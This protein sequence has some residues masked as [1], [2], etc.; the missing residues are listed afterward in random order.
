MQCSL[1]NRSNPISQL[2]VASTGESVKTLTRLKNSKPF[3]FHPPIIPL[4]SL[5]TFLTNL[6]QFRWIST[7]DTKSFITHTVVHNNTDLNYISHQRYFTN[8]DLILSQKTNKQ[9]TLFSHVGDSCFSVFVF[10]F[11]N[12]K[13]REYLTMSR[14]PGNH[15]RRLGDNGGL[16]SSSKSRSSP[17]ISLGLIVVVIQILV[18][19]LFVVLEICF[20]GKELHGIGFL[21][22]KIFLFLQGALLFIAYSYRNSGEMTRTPFITVCVYKLKI[23]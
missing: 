17:I 4:Q 8:S 13:K 10:V 14:R 1:Q 9:C 5:P 18:F 2:R 12:Q 11:L 3:S 21:I 19:F 7:T 20:T 6:P 16:F 23:D 15:A 22:Q